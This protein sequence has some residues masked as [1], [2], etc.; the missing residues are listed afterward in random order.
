MIEVKICGITNLE[1]AL[2]VVKSGADMIGFIL[3]SG[4][5]RTITPEKAKSII[6]M[7]PDT[8]EK[9]GV[10]V[11][12]S[13]ARVNE[14]AEMLDI[15][16]IQLHGSESP[17]Y[18]SKVSKPVIKTIRVKDE[19][20]INAIKNYDAADFIL[21][22]TYAEDKFGGTGRTFDWALAAKAKESKKTIMLSGGLNPKN[23]TT[24]IEI[25]KPFG[26]DVASGVEER[27]GK[28]DPKKIREFVKVVRTL[29]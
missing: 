17:D 20:S 12:E 25:V 9:V 8:I 27:P 18:C 23:I 2:E 1:D 11:D 29:Q 7:L 14:L 26:V 6:E 16:Y 4:S 3:S 21:L 28:K 22:D 15:D 24:A 13:L 19:N 5:P 10:F